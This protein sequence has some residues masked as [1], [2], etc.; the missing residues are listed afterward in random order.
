MGRKQ[1]EG[2]GSSTLLGKGWGGSGL[3]ELLV[4]LGTEGSTGGQRPAHKLLGHVAGEGATCFQVLG[5]QG[6]SICRGSSTEGLCLGPC[7]SC[8]ESSVCPAP[9]GGRSPAQQ[10]TQ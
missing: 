1:G 8:S 3:E 10:L 2:P 9:P 7:L 4:H 5:P 6:Q